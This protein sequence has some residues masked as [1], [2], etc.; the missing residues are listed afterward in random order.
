MRGYG[1]CVL[2]HSS[3]KAQSATR[4]SSR[5]AS[6]LAEEALG[7]GGDKGDFDEQPDEGF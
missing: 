6:L 3:M 4:L 1:L 2:V 5:R 7:E